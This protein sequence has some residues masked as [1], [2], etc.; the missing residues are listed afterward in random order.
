MIR[1]MSDPAIPFSVGG[2]PDALYENLVQTFATWPP[3][4]R[5]GSPRCLPDACDLLADQ[6]RTAQ[7]PRLRDV[8]LAV[9][10]TTDPARWADTVLARAAAGSK[11]LQRVADLVNGV[12]ATWPAAARLPLPGPDADW[13]AWLAWSS[14]TSLEYKLVL[15]PTL[16][17]KRD[18]LRFEDS[19]ATAI[20]F[21]QARTGRDVIGEI[22]R[23][24]AAA[25]DD[26]ARLVYGTFLTGLGDAPDVGQIAARFRSGSAEQI[27]LA[28]RQVYALFGRGAPLADSTTTMA[29]LDRL[30]AAAVDT[31]APWPALTMLGRSVARPTVATYVLVDSIPAVLRARWRDRVRFLTSA[32]W[33]RMPEREAAT[34]LILSSVERI[35]PFVRVRTE[36]SERLARRPNETP[37]LAHGGIGYYLLA[38]GDGWVVAAQDMWT[39]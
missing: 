11:V 36:V 12:G 25:T 26:S 33:Q 38:S 21:Y 10:A 2:S 29:I 1:V 16:G 6:W 27:A 37:W 39:T 7:E 23:N 19:H 8:G 31:V 32:E 13:R 15:S 30:I 3:A 5:A 35:G 24:L 14:A 18:Q 17:G 22:R 4:V 28:E 34:L 9:L 20:G